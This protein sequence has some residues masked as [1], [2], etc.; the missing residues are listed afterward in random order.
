M[1]KLFINKGADIHA[2]DKDGNTLLHTT[3]SSEVAKIL[4]ENKADIN[5]KNNNDYTPLLAT[6]SSEIAK[7]LIE[8]GANVN[9]KDQN[10]N[11]L[12]HKYYNDFEMTKLL[13][14]KGANRSIANN[15]G[16][17][18]IDYARRSGNAGVLRLLGASEAE[19]AT[20]VA[21][22]EQRDQAAEANRRAQADRDREKREQANRD[23]DQKRIGKEQCLQT[24]Y[25]NWSST[26]T[27]C[28][29]KN[30]S[31]S[32]LRECQACESKCKSTYGN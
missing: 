12:L 31:T 4:I 27:W 29:D 20:A 10:G 3:K 5:A 25:N 23:S 14:S 16:E 22:K 9:V 1:I 7:L 21:N 2:K 11:T 15:K 32:N 17:L 18:P 26:S 19:I 28:W 13:I 6:D 8:K 24:C 30:L